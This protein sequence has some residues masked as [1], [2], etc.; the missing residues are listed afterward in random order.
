MSYARF[1]LPIILL[2]FSS[3]IKV[4]VTGEAILK[5]APELALKLVNVAA[6]LVIYLFKLCFCLTVISFDLSKALN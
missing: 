2:P 6:A 3:K 1:L 5:E 4:N